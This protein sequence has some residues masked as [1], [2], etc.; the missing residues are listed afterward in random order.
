MECVFVILAAGGHFAKRVLPRPGNKKIPALLGADGDP[1]QWKIK[2]P[3]G[4]VTDG[5]QAHAR[6][7][8]VFGLDLDNQVADLAGDGFR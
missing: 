4:F 1:T 3:L 8:P 7:L 6:T 2:K 5:R